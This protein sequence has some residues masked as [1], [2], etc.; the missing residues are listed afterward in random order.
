VIWPSTRPF[1]FR[2][3]QPML[4]SVANAREIAELTARAMIEAN[5]GRGAATAPAREAPAFASPAAA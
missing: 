2:Q 1:H 5:G 3:P 4:R